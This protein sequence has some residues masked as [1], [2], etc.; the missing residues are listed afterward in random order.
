MQ[1]IDAVIFDTDG[2]ITRTATVHFAAWKHVFDSF[3]TSHASGPSAAPFTDD[4]YRAHVDGIGR[5]DGVDAMLRSRGI[6]LPRG[7]PSDPPGDSTVC[8]VANTKNAAFE[9][10]VATDGVAPYVTTRRFVEALH[11]ADIRT[12]VISAS[13][14]CE[15][16]LRVAGMADLFEVRVDGI[17]QAALGFP[18]KPSP[19]VFLEAARRLG[20]DPLHAAVVEDAISGVAAGRAG[21]FGL[22]IGLDRSLNPGPLAEHADLVVPDAADLEVVGIDERGHSIQRAQPAR[23]VASDLPHALD[24]DDLTRRTAG[25]PIAVFCDYDGTLTPIVDRP[26]DA[27]L[28]PHV[29]AQLEALADLVPVAIVSGRGLDDV[30]SMIASDKFWISGSHGFE[31]RSPEGTYHEIELGTDALPALAQA[32]ANLEE[33]VARVPGARVEPKRYAT[34]IHYRETPEH[35][36]GELE[37]LVSQ[38]VERHDE[39]RMTGGKAI[40]ELR[41]AAQWDKGRAIEWLLDA[42]DTGYALTTPVFFGDDLTDEDGFV[43]VR[44]TGV[45]ILVAPEHDRRITAALDRANSTDEVA[46]ILERLLAHARLEP[47]G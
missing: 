16:V 37:A 27:R 43:A 25:R 15:M 44:T 42:I 46:R 12:A 21:G 2:V 20:V 24:D 3:L 1:R 11:A 39:L 28:D 18:G 32:T 38:E 13:K 4:D 41:P 22:V 34:A 17:D 19:D 35:L 36:H 47:K 9:E 40:F 14:N 33:A 29:L 10:A 30:A 5:Y 26:E 8:A 23:T 31:V 6:E 45:G 7:D